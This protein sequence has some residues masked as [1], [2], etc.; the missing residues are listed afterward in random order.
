MCRCPHSRYCR[1][2][3][4]RYS[5]KCARSFSVYTVN[6][7]TVADRSSLSC[8]ELR[9]QRVGCVI[10]QIAVAVYYKWKV[11]C[12]VKRMM[13]FQRVRMHRGMLSALRM[14]GGISTILACASAIMFTRGALDDDDDLFWEASLMGWGGTSVVWSTVSVLLQHRPQRQ[15]ADWSDPHTSPSYQNQGLQLSFCH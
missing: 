12:A 5:V 1:P 14:C 9:Y 13:G 7:M 8:H 6:V 2:D 3:R 4:L 10:E 11:K 15:V